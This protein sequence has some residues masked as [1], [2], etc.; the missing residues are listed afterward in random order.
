MAVLKNAL[1]EPTNLYRLDVLW[2]ADKD[3]FLIVWTAIK[4]QIEL[5]VHEGMPMHMEKLVYRELL[6]KLLEGK[7]GNEVASEESFHKRN[8]YIFV[9]TPLSVLVELTLSFA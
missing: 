1:K 4:N 5:V 3:H 9:Y 2:I 7:L 8:R 6:P